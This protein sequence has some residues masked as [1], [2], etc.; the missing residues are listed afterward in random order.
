MQVEK[1]TN[2]C[3]L[4]CILPTLLHTPHPAIRSKN[5]PIG[6][7]TFALRHIWGLEFR[8]KF[9][10]QFNSTPPTLVEMYYNRSKSTPDRPK[11]LIHH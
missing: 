11:L 2:F 1:K 9:S 5:E 7:R 10:V 6:V 3:S 8:S 4:S